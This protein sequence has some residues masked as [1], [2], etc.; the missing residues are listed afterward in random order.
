MNTEALVLMISTWTLVIGMLIYYFQKLL[1]KQA[2][3]NRLSD[4]NAA[5]TPEE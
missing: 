2:Q 4:G 1:R 3:A 5:D